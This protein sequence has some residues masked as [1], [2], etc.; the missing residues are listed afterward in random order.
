[1]TLHALKLAPDDSALKLR[2]PGG[3]GVR[4]P[5][6]V[7]E[8]EGTRARPQDNGG[9]DPSRVH[10]VPPIGGPPSRWPAP[11]KAV[12]RSL[13]D[14]VPWLRKPDRVMMRALVI[15]E[16]GLRAADTADPR[17]EDTIIKWLGQVHRFTVKLGMNP[18]DRTRVLPVT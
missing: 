3:R 14:E 8:V 17:N 2:R 9:A 5:A 1:M 11:L 4:T 6:E 16:D 7:R 15:A 12:W 10:A 18:C 13:K